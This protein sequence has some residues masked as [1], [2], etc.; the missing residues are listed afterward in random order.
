M[1]NYLKKNYKNL[2]I[3][4]VLAFL[5]IGVLVGCSSDKLSTK[6]LAVKEIDEKI[7]QSVDVS[8]LNKGDKDKLK[9]LY[10]VDDNEIEDFIL[11]TAQSNIEADEIAIIK[12]NKDE[13]IADVKNKISKRLEEQSASFKDYLPDEYYVIE[14]HVLK[15]KGKYILFT[16]SEDAEKIEDI[17]DECFK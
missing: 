5:T 8:N 13:K 2:F 12:V 7:K 17:F 1:I 14:K 15:T 11:Y 16:I 6:N 4:L 9:R 3:T 10:D